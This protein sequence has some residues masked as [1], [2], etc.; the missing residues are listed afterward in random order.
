MSIMFRRRLLTKL[1]WR[2]SLRW[3]SSRMCLPTGSSPISKTSRR[4]SRKIKGE[5]KKIDLVTFGTCDN[6]PW[7][8]TSMENGM[9]L[10]QRLCYGP[11]SRL[12]NTR[13][14]SRSYFNEN[15]RNTRSLIPVFSEDTSTRRREETRKVP[16]GW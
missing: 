5:Q 2:S 10:E 9:G 12:E 1:L 6:T 11:M 16:I 8:K 14:K 15:G 7:L 4:E 13:K 3:R